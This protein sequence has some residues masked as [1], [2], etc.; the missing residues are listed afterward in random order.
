[1]DS[2]LEKIPVFM[3]GG[4]IIPKKER[5]RRSSSQMADDPF[6]IVVAADKHVKNFL[7]DSR[8]TKTIAGKCCWQIIP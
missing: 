3:Q 8:P 1:M 7:F 6:T 2:P 4:S 5:P